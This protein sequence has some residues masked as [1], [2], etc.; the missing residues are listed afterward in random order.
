MPNEMGYTPDTAGA[1]DVMDMIE[2]DNASAIK[3]VFVQK[4]GEAFSAQGYNEEV[5]TRSYKNA[6]NIDREKVQEKVANSGVDENMFLAVNVNQI[7]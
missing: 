7:F 1:M 3:S 2:E 6:S 5:I 4:D